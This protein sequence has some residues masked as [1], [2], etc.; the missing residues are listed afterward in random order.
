MERVT[1]I[2]NEFLAFVASMPEPLAYVIGAGIAVGFGASITVAI[3]TYRKKWKEAEKYTKV[4]IG[5]LL[6]AIAYA[7]STAYYLV[8]NASDISSAL[9]IPYLSEY[10]K[11]VL[12]AWGAALLVANKFYELGG[13]K[14]YQRFYDKI[15]P[16][17]TAWSQKRQ[18]DKTTTKS[19]IFKTSLPK[20]LVTVR[21][22]NDEDSDIFA[23]DKSDS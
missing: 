14:L 4:F 9:S 21:T 15:A 22:T 17:L 7:M 1:T 16:K 23:S 8:A 20:P 2:I 5:F 6:T 19:A 3:I 18:E 13:S 11:H 10:A 12:P